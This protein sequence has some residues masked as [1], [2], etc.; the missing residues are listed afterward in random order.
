MH[1][2]AKIHFQLGNIYKDLELY[3]KALEVSV[4]ASSNCIPKSLEGKLGPKAL[5]ASLTLE[6]EGKL[7]PKALKASLALKP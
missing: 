1:L 6:L 7:D 5:K 2:T 4:V 3:P